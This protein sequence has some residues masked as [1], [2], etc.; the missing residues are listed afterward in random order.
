MEFM[1]PKKLKVEE[2]RAEAD[3]YYARYVFSPLEKGYGITIGNALRR[4]LLSS[5]PSIAIVG[6]RFLKPERFHEFDTLPGVKEDILEII[7]N[8]KKV[9]LRAEI[10]VKEKL[11]MTVEKKGP[12]LLLAGDIRTP[13]GIE[14]MNPGLKIA[15]LDDEA[16]LVF[17]LYV[18]AGKGFVPAQEIEE[19][20]EIGSI[21]IDGVFSPVIKVNFKVESARVAK[22]TDYDKLVLEVWT[23][24]TIFPHE[25]MKR[26]IDTLINHFKVIDESL[27]STMAPLSAEFVAVITQ[28]ETSAEQMSHSE[29]ES[30]YSKKID[31]LELSIRSLN[32]LRRDK[33][34]TIG[35]LLKRTEE[36][37]L[38][39][40]NFGPKSLEEVKQKLFE[41]FGLTLKKGG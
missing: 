14:V 33:I 26:A 39:I 8:L 22:R 25:A 28:E 29:E 16:D 3:H 34:E 9:Q 31:E 20:P 38:K 37:L 27:P 23:K 41:K 30:I 18:Q 12:G 32:C 13:A 1:I 15:T 4:V 2:E 19:H 24:K 10:P 17:E 21:P 40:K 5:I 36:D 35:D 6:V 7:L 11:K